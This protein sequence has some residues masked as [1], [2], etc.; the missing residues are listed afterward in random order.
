MLIW[1][2]NMTFIKTILFMALALTAGQSIAQA[3]AS[4][5]QEAGLIIPVELTNPIALGLDAGV[6]REY[7]LSGGPTDG[8][9]LRWTWLETEEH[10]GQNYQWFETQLSTQD[11]KMVT[12]LLANP[13]RLSEAPRVVLMK[14]NNA[15]AQSMPNEL[16]QKSV[17]LLNYAGQT[18]AKSVADETLEV[19]AGKYKTKLYS[20]FANGVTQKTY[21]S[22]SLPGIVLTETE[23]FRMELIA[24]GS[25]GSSA[26][27]EKPA[28]ATQ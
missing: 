2:R 9:T 5:P 23:G 11:R 7:S 18:P 14:V 25:D 15:P 28:S 12:K 20:I 10:D 1:I 19:V 8:A 26:I 3:E 27:T 6:W 21:I 4:S 22:E 17:E 13:S 16:R 24:I